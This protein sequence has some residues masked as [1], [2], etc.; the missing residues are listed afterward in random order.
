MA[1]TKK[2]M[3]LKKPQKPA[4]PQ[5]RIRGLIELIPYFKRYRKEIFWAGLALLVTALMILCFGKVVKY[6]VDTGLGYGKSD[7][8]LNY[9]IIFFVVAILIMAVAGYFRSLLINQVCEKAIADLRID[10]YQKVIATSP[11]FFETTKVGDVV[12]RLTSDSLLIYSV[13]TG[14]LSFLL[15][16]IILFCGSFL[17][18][19]FT[20]LKLSL[21]A[22]IAILIAILPIPLLLSKIK[23][24]SKASQASF[25]DL[26]SHIEESVSGIRTIQSYLCEEKETKNFTS[27]IDNFLRISLEKGRVKAL[28]ISIVIFLAFGAVAFLLW[29]GGKEILSGNITSGALSSFLF[30]AAIC[31]TSLLGIGQVM[32]QLQG[33]SAA[34]E[35]IFELMQIEPFVKESATPLKIINSESIVLELKNVS[36]SYPARP[37]ALVLSD[38]NLKIAPK[39]K[40]AIIGKSGSGKSTIFQLLLRFYDATSGQILINGIDAKNL[41]LKDL[42]SL[43]SYISQDCFIFS[44]SVFEN[45]SYLNR[46]T[47]KEEVLDLIERNPALHFIKSLPEGIHSFI[48]EKGIKLSGGEKQR[49]AI[50]RAILNDAPIMLLDEATSA[51]D[52]QNEQIINSFID[53]IS[54]KKTI[55]V[56][57]HRLSSVV[58][59]DRIIFIKEGRVVE[60]G[61]HQDLMKLDG[62][63]KKL[64]EK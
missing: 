38:F 49:I 16:N 9:V 24:L 53:S 19:F 37:E 52:N 3:I 43:F 50:A 64:Y 56:V 21:L 11:Q 59:C 28:M 33:A 36:F 41:A 18:L 47:S 29:V 44:G 51:L 48:G 15:R 35:R 34:S 54:H 39:E 46:K 8:S 2:I 63:Y 45:I 60:E 12:S 4:K 61:S 26:S 5:S 23:S 30:Y 57:T 1:N 27:L 22:I 7:S 58:N 13:L 6:L 42:R 14:S 55:I 17:F 10:V 62:E 20:S 32:T 31:A 40:I 25:S